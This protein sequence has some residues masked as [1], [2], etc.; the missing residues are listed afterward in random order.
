MQQLPSSVH[1]QFEY[2][3]QQSVLCLHSA[4]CE[5][6]SLHLIKYLLLTGGEISRCSL[7]VLVKLEEYEKSQVLFI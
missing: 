1:S 3:M 4:G 7:T 5:P 2:Y 6:V